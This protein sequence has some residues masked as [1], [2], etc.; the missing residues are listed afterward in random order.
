MRS[1]FSRRNT[2]LLAILGGVLSVISVTQTWVTAT[3]IPSLTATDVTL[4]GQDASPVVGAMAL[5]AVASAVV[6]SMVHS[7]GRVIIGIAMI[8]LGVLMSWATIAVLADPLRHAQQQMAESVG[9]ANIEGT[10][11]VSSITYLA[12]VGA[13]LVFC[14]G[15]IAVSAGR[16]WSTKASKKYTRATVES[17]AGVYPVPTTGTKPPGKKATAEAH[18]PATS[19]E[20]LD[21]I[22]AWD[23]L[24]RGEDPTV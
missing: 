8:F 11:S 20:T 16:N 14:A 21:E 4:R 15:I 7:L 3:D 24:T 6:M 13:V 19:D 23:E 17:A 10:I 1:I 12:L 2:V 5:V 18:I 22:D 9:V